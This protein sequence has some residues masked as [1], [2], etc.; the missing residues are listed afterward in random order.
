M[1]SD[2]RVRP[3]NP[4]NQST[5][6]EDERQ[7]LSIAQD[8]I[9]CNSKGR[10]KFP[11][12]TSLAI[13]VH[14]LTTSKRLIELLNKMGHCV[15]YDE[16]RA[17][18][19]SIAED[20][21]A[22]AE[23]FGTVIPTVIKAGS[24]VQIAADN[25]DLN[26]ETIDGKTTTHATTMV[27]YQNRTFGPDPPPSPVEQRPKRRSLQA[28]GTVYDIE[29]CPVRGRRPAVTD[30]VGS[31][32]M[33]WYDDLNNETGTARKADF[34]WTLLRLCPKKFGEA[35]V[36]DVWEKQSIPSWA[37]FNAIL[38]PEMPVVSNIGYCPMIDGSSNDFSTIYTV[39]KHAQKI[40]AAMGKADAV[41]TFDLAIY[42]KAK[43]IQ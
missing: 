16:M 27:I 8:I 24:F 32:D 2:K 23:E 19:T 33:K 41:V 26:E 21:L 18:N 12:H 13:C 5:A 29:Q 9:H 42:S 40:S 31:V 14:H 17:V 11:K 4:L 36:A 7:I 15:S 39:L 38:Y 3:S 28:T 25:N 6:I 10:V 37:G 43:E 22:K 30:H 1:V 34:V 35:V 20:V